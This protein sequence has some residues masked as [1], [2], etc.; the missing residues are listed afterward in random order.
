MARSQDRAISTKYPFY[1]IDWKVEKSDLHRSNYIRR[2]MIASQIEPKEVVHRSYRTSNIVIDE[3]RKFLEIRWK[4]KVD[5]DDYKKTMLEAGRLVEEEN[6]SQAIINRLELDEISPESALWLKKEFVKVHLKPIINKLKKVATV[7][8]KS[9]FSRF[10]SN[11]L[12]LAI[13]VVYPGLSIKSFSSK[14]EAF[15]WMFDHR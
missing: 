11:S 2:Q 5:Y 12:T 15:G 10:Y 9:A 4:G 3:E 1:G 13:K 8:S 6:F 7:E 14:E